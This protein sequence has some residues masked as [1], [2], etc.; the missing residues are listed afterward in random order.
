MI[1]TPILRGGSFETWERL[2]ERAMACLD[3]IP[4]AK[5]PFRAGASVVARLSVSRSGTAIAMTSTSSLE[6]PQ[7]LSVLSPRLNDTVS[8]LCQDYEEDTQFS[9]LVMMEGEVDFIAAPLLTSPG[10]FLRQIGGRRVSLETP[11][12]I[13]QRSSS[14]EEGYSVHETC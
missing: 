12:E 1:A 4:L 10:M 9:K 13:M 14:F 3:S 5:V 11:A 8:G 7:W 2:F 6:G